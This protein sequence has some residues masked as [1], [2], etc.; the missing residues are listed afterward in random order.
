[1]A[2]NE[3]PA[4]Q[5]TSIEPVKTDAK[6]AKASKKKKEKTGDISLPLLVEFIFAFSAIF[7]ILVF[8]AM[9]TVSWITGTTLLDFFLRTS[10]AI[11]VLGGLFQV[12]SRQVSD[13]VLSANMAEQEIQATPKESAPIEN[14]ENSEFQTISEA[15]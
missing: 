9:S 8:L 4:E 1:M 7:L 11:L 12:L 15:Q 2:E 5:Q 13:G 14:P 3:K 10:V 6:P